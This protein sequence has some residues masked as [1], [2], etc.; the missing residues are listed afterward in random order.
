MSNT[1]QDSISADEKWADLSQQALEYAK[2]S[3]WGMYTNIQLDMADLL[4]KEGKQRHE[5]ELLFWVLYLDINGPENRKEVPPDLLKEFPPFDPEMAVV[6]PVI[7]KRA[8][9]LIASLGMDVN[10]ARIAFIHGTT[11][12]RNKLMPIS[13]DQAWDKLQTHIATLQEEKKS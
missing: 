4:K 8:T 10:T 13:P 7:A 3:E 2:H 11:R 6:A 1:I 12:R 5:L 9:S